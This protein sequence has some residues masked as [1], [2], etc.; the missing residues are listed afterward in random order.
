MNKVT[1]QEKLLA[2]DLNALFDF[3]TNKLAF[4]AHNL[5]NAL[6]GFQNCFRTCRE[7]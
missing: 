4:I 6:H 7:N 2:D 3:A 5:S 1:A